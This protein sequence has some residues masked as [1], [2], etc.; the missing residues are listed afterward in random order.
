M[1]N[2]PPQV[3]TILVTFKIANLIMAIRSIV[4][5]SRSDEIN[6]MVISV[7]EISAVKT[8]DAK[9][10]KICT[11]YLKYADSTSEFRVLKEMKYALFYSFSQ[12]MHNQISNSKFN[13]YINFLLVK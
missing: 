4:D 10:R 13:S 5:I 12:C 7:P 1:A 8:K 11:Y 9:N 3:N 2:K 6:K